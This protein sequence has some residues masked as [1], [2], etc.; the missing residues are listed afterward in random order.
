[1]DRRK[2]P[3]MRHVSHPHALSGH[4]VVPQNGIRG[5]VAP[6]ELV[7]IRYRARRFP[8]QAHDA[9]GIGAGLWLAVSTLVFAHLDLEQATAR[10][11]RGSA[12][13]S[14]ELSLQEVEFFLAP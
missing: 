4:A 3:R 11:A 1:M 10:C 9:G 7:A 6:Q 13:S 8:A 14:D 2:P 12:L 5:P